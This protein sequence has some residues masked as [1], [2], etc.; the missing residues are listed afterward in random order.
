M[1]RRRDRGHEIDD[2]E[3]RERKSKSEVPAMEHRSSSDDKQQQRP[4][5][6]QELKHP[7]SPVLNGVILPLISD[8]SILLLSP[9]DRFYF[10]KK[11]I[12]VYMNY[13][14]MFYDVHSKLLK[15]I[16]NIINNIY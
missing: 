2:R 9:A 6:S 14:N 10:V 5:S 16:K 8:V 1:I 12:N 4:R 3:Q 11:I 15:L 13:V 7:R